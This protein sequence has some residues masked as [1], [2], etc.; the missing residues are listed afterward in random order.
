MLKIKTTFILLFSL[1]IAFLLLI[2]LAFLGLLKNR[3][4]FGESQ[5]G[6]L[7]SITLSDQLRERNDDLTHYCL[8]YIITGDE[9][10]EADY[11][12]L[13]ESSLYRFPS[14]NKGFQLLE[15]SI[16]QLGYGK[17]EFELL[18]KAV[19]LSI[20]L[21]QQE[22]MAMQMVKDSDNSRVNKR[23]QALELISNKA[24]AD[25]KR[26]LINT[27]VAFEQRIVAQTE[28]ARQENIKEG[29]RLYHVVLALLISV[30]AFS[31]V[32]LFLILKRVNRQAQ[33]D[34]LFKSG[35]ERQKQMQ[36][37]L[38]KSDERFRLAV[39]GSGA[40]IWD[41]QV[42]QSKLTW[43]PSHLHLLGYAPHEVKPQM[44]FLLDVM[45][46]D[47]RSKFKHHLEQ[48]IQEGQ[49]FNID[50]RFYSKTGELR[51]CRCRGNSSRES[52]GVAQ[53]V[54]GI[55][56]DI[57]DRVKAEE[58]ATNA[59]LETED[60][61]RSRIARDIHDSLQQTMST[62]LLNFEKVRSSIGTD[63]ELLTERYQTGYDYLKKAI[64]DSRFLA[65]KLMPKVVDENGL[66][67]A[68]DALVG[69]LKGSSDTDI[70]FYQ[71]L[72]EERLPLAAEMTMYRIVQ[73]A[74][75][76]VLKYAK[77][78]ECIIQLFKR[79]NIVTLTIED[80]GLGFDLK[81]EG[82]SFGLNSMRTRAES[83]G[84]FYQ[85]ETDLGRDTQILIELSL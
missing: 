17:V 57:T 11:W 24:Y 70:Q 72:N 48:H 5:I 78:Q 80:D 51:W 63:D 4:S 61:E 31:L 56:M 85:I 16:R 20:Q 71:N 64:S 8:N 39:E 50:V 33:Q 59:I 29:M 66:A 36:D 41:Y 77:A 69:A 30:I 26:Q 54:V 76:N 65:H 28:K 74:V 73:E 82:G 43:S 47:D 35:V 58:R 84:A 32:V 62:A 67:L 3:T 42:N 25:N 44:D 55:F 81:K 18:K 60:R 12:Q 15:D 40:R 68:I 27:I 22:A 13:S 6:Q 83:I 37:E 10:W 21:N 34:A 14:K 79:N 9:K 52:S 38:Q 19:Y 7:H 1:V 2:L 75:N 53:R 23:D 45:H 46:I 49:S